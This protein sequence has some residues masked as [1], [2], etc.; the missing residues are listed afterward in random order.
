MDPEVCFS[1]LLGCSQC[2]QVI[3]MVNHPKPAFINLTPKHLKLH[4]ISQVHTVRSSFPLTCCDFL[5]CSGD[6]VHSVLQLPST[7]AN[8]M[9]DNLSLIYRSHKMAAGTAP[10]SCPQPHTQICM[11]KNRK[12][13]YVQ[14]WSFFYSRKHLAVSPCTITKKTLHFQDKVAQSKHSFLLQTGPLGYRKD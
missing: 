3:I 14:F 11:H 4:L 5:V 7:S 8:E 13:F 9:P 12:K 6:H 1:S 2:D 10:Q